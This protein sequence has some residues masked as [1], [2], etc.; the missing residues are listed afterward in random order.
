MMMMGGSSK[1]SYF[2]QYPSS[3]SYPLFS[4]CFEVLQLALFFFFFSFVSG[5]W[6]HIFGVCMVSFNSLINVVC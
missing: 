3:L 4:K 6:S 1:K 5:L 2:I